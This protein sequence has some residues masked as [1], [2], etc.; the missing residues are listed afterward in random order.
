LSNTN[1]YFADVQLSPVP[2][3]VCSDFAIH[4]F[5]KKTKQKKNSFST[6][7]L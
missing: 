4:C 1:I 5:R 3:T 7:P 2:L 6:Q